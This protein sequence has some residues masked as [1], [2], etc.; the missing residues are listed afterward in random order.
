MSDLSLQL[1]RATGQ[2]PVSSYFDAALFQR[3]IT[4][5]FQSGPRYVGHANSVPELGDYATLLQ[6]GEG[7]A[8][9]HGQNG[10]ELVSNVCRHRQA[11]MLK[12]RG[13]LNSNGGNIVCP[14]HRWTYGGSNSEQPGRLIGAPHFSHDPCL[15]LKRYGLREW[16]GLLDLEVTRDR[17]W[18]FDREERF[19]GMSCIGAAIRDARGEVVA[20]VS[21]SGPSI[22]FADGRIEAFGKLVAE[23]ASEISRGIGGAG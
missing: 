15:N 1:Q 16:N 11:I 3:E 7:R 14:V 21:I 9:V 18:S 19:A 8:L 17:G 4:Q 6:E 12:G 22:R 13:S 5:L 10:I 2:L 20:G 23:A